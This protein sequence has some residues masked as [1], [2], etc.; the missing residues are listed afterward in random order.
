MLVAVIKEHKFIGQFTFGI[1][2]VVKPIEK[3][4]FIFI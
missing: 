1:S 4:W 2:L 3:V